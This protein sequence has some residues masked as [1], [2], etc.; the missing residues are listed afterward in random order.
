ML[1]MDRI[2]PARVIRRE[3]FPTNWRNVPSLVSMFGSSHRATASLIS[4]FSVCLRNALTA[5][6]EGESGGEAALGIEESKRSKPKRLVLILESIIFLGRRIMRFGFPI[7][8]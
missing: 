7:A 5:C 8:K 4:D 6:T 2:P 1:V 3:S